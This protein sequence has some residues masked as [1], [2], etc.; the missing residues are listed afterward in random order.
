VLTG[1]KLVA[2]ARGERAV[3][4]NRGKPMQAV[5]EILGAKALTQGALML[6][7]LGVR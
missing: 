1:A 4:M 5:I 3:E 2:R 7:E 6:F